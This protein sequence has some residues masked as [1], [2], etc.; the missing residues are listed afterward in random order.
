MANKSMGILLNDTGDLLIRV[1]KNSSGL[2][3]QGLVVGNVTKQ[4]QR[5][6]LSAEK[7]EIKSNPTLGVGIR[8]YL[9]DEDFSRLLRE[10]RI[11]LR[12]DGQKVKSC[13]F[14]KQGNIII[15]GGY[16]N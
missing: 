7:G 6:I 12:E 4:N 13:G 2:I 1:V 5:T 14:D 15:Q 10:T 3:T 8:S 9:D 16:E 11:K